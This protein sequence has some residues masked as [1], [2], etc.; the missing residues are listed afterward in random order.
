MSDPD[1]TKY[2][3]ERASEQFSDGKLDRV[4]G[5]IIKNSR[6][7]NTDQVLD[8]HGIDTSGTGAYRAES[9]RPLSD[10]KQEELEEQ[11]QDAEGELK[12][13]RDNP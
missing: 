5:A 12:R 4:R 3:F 6:Y 7:D 8:N 13:L 2:P 1:R 11:Y 9:R 10:E